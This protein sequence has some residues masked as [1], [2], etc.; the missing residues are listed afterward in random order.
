M[1]TMSSVT[2]CINK[3]MENPNVSAEDVAGIGIT[4]QRETT[5][6]WDKHTGEPLYKALVWCDARTGDIVRKYTLDC[7]DT[8][9]FRSVC[10]LPISTYF[11]AVKL[12]WLMENVPRVKVDSF[13]A[14]LGVAR[15]RLCS[16]VLW[17]SLCVT[18]GWLGLDGIRWLRRSKT[19]GP[20]SGQS[21]RGSF[22]T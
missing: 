3:V 1:E 12:R 7:G 6:V 19:A 18:H 22:G 4:N 5:V 2:Q 14:V 15:V 20:C 17:R 21:K 16:G 11:S 9:Y 13:A 8:D 10:G